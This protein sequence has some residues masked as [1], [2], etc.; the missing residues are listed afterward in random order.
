MQSPAMSRKNALCEKYIRDCR[1]A[2]IKALKLSRKDLEHGLALHANSLVFDAFCL[3]FH[4]PVDGLQLKQAMAQGASFSEIRAMTVRMSHLGWLAPGRKEL[5]R[6]ILRASGLTGFFQNV[7]FDV[8]PTGPDQFTR[9]AY[10][11]SLARALPDVYTLNPEPQNHKPVNREPPNRE[12]VNLLFSL[13]HVPLA[14]EF[15]SVADELR[16]LELCRNLGVRMMHLTYNRQNLLGG[17]CY[18]R[19]DGGLSDFGRKAVRKMNELGII[20]DVSHCGWRTSEDAARVSKAPI[21]ASHTACCGLHAHPRGKP[22]RV[23]KAIAAGGGYVGICCIPPFL[24]G[25]RDISAMLEHVVYAVKKIGAGHVAIGTDRN[26]TGPEAR[27]EARK[28]PRPSKFFRGAHP[29]P[30]ESG[31]EFGCGDQAE[32]PEHLKTMEL[33]NWPLFTAGLVQRGLKDDAIQKIIGGNVMRL[34]GWS[35]RTR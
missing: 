23:L 21:V 35:Q 34:A 30:F 12:P 5:L 16:H 20:P 22:D 32:K 6:L 10:F 9:L 17:G 2:A 7:E 18:E 15:R 25:R 26:F 19:S 8:T 13:N 28:Y 3:G 27:I 24:G 14:Y 4:A 33:V 31:F 1:N 11:T 29:P